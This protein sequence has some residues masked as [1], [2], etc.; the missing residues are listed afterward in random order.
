MST[1]R[2]SVVAAILAVA[3]EL[4]ADDLTDD[5]RLQEDLDLDSMDFLDVVTGLAERT[6]VDIPERDYP[7]LATIGG[8][9]AYLERHT[10]T[11]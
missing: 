11:A 7:E 2:E 4:D 10:A 1:T 5:A 6:G 9:A 8:A 3:P